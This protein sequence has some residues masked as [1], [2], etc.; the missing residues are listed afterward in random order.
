MESKRGPWIK[1]EIFGKI[2]ELRLETSREGEDV[3]FWGGGGREPMGKYHCRKE[4]LQD[5]Y[6]VCLSTVSQT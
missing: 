5:E 2:S 4:G 1:G 3:V 6:A